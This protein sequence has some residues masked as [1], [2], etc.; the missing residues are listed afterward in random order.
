MDNELD[1]KKKILLVDD[2][3]TQHVIV[4]NMLKDEYDIR[5]AKSGD[6]ALRYLYSGDYTPNLVLLDILMPNMNG[7]EVF[8][9]IKA[10]SLL[11]N[12]PIAFFTSVNESSD[13][14]KA[15]DIGADD[16]I[17]KPYEKE[18]LKNRIKVI[19]EKAAEN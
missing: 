7:W 18:S 9:R 16:Y 13:E 15:F 2:D 19:L 11:K 5:G 8:N 6:E 4:G 10:I 1:E 17:T 3:G 14:K 12:V